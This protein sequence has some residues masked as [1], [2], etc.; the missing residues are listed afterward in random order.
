MDLDGI[1]PE[2]QPSL[3]IPKTH[4]LRNDVKFIVDTYQTDIKLHQELAD[5]NQSRSALETEI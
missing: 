2:D 3:S 4:L 5:A 1:H